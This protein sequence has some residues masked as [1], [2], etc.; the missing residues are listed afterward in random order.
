IYMD[1][2]EVSSSSS[3]S[4]SSDEE[5]TQEQDKDNN[6]ATK[7]D[8]MGN[9]VTICDINQAMLDVGKKR[10]KALGYSSGEV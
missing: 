5:N 8:A 10:A 1:P 4:S 6:Y 7:P 3:S 2:A 9:H